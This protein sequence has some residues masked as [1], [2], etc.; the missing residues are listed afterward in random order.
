[1]DGEYLAQAVMLDALDEIATRGADGSRTSW[2]LSEMALR[3][4]RVARELI[5]GDGSGERAEGEGDES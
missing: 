5:G 4:R 3:A 1:M 2:E